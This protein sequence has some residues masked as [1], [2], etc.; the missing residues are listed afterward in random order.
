[1]PSRSYVWISRTSMGLSRRCED[2]GKRERR[3]L[4]HPSA[5]KKTHG[6]GEKGAFMLDLLK[7]FVRRNGTGRNSN[8]QVSHG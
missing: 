3:I 1:M 7:P 8:S 4:E 6:N 5:A 2:Q